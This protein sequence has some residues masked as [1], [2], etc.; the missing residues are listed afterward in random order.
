MA[1]PTYSRHVVLQTGRSDW[2]SKIEDEEATFIGHNSS[3]KKPANL[4][5]VLKSLPGKNILITNSNSPEPDRKR[6]GV[7]VF[8]H[9]VFVPY[10]NN[11]QDAHELFVRQ[12]LL[13]PKDIPA[14]KVKLYNEPTKVTVKQSLFYKTISSRPTLF[15][16]SHN[17]RDSRCGILG[18]LLLEEFDTYIENRLKT[19]G[20][21]NQGPEPPTR[22][23]M[24]R[25]HAKPLIRT[26][27]ISHIGGHAWAGN[28]IIYFPKTY[29]RSVE[30]KGYHPLAGKGIWYGRV[31]PKHVEGIMEQ[32]VEGGYVIE[33]LLR[34]VHHEPHLVVNNGLPPVASEQ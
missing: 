22:L 16:C 34:G 8:P 31:E 21:M 25:M 6:N 24:I 2:A 23:S 3:S 32:T 15:I 4:A 9:C 33:E 13:D 28:V 11:I 17:T 26:A 30:D 19:L 18:P 14:G 5:K 20:R 1:I 29:R 10:L 7:Y 27:L 12:F